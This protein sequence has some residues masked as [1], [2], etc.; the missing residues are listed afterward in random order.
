MTF[1]EQPNYYEVLNISPHAKPQEIRNAYLRVKSAYNKD[2]LAMYTL[3]SLEDRNDIL[4]KIEEAYDILSSPEKRKRYDM[5]FTDPE[6]SVS[7]L[8]FD[9][10]PDLNKIISID[11]SPPME[12]FLDSESLL[13][14]PSTDFEA[15]LDRLDVSNQ[16]TSSEFSQPDEPRKPLN[17]T[18]PKNSYQ[19]SGQSSPGLVKIIASETPIL[20]S[21]ALLPRGPLAPE[22][23]E[24]EGCQAKTEID[25][26]AEIDGEVEFKGDFLRRIREIRHISI[27]EMSHITK[28][29]KTYLTAI[30]EENFMRLPAA[31]YVRGFVIQVA[32]I[33][34]LPFQKV[35]S[36]YMSRFLQETAQK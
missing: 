33:L 12:T 24:K 20:S 15:P 35:S 8:G 28:I 34:K 4:R 26:T 14:P 21:A 11:R 5:G 29:S 22:K 9:P 3:I 31:V 19:K 10:Q 30:E 6:L 2:S 16:R 27:E 25:L 23:V 18:I 13:I 17:E 32:R 36:A 7:K 1:E